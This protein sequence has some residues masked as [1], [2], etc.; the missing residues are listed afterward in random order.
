MPRLHRL[1]LKNL[2]RIQ[3]TVTGLLLRLPIVELTETDTMLAAITITTKELGRVVVTAKVDL[4]IVAEAAT[5]M[6]MALASGLVVPVADTGALPLPPF[7]L[8]T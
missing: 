6:A 4:P 1:H 5:A 3:R 2:P 8:A 7:H